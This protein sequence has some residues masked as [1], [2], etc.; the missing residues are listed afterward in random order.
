M[1]SLNGWLKTAPDHVLREQWQW[2][3]RYGTWR[4]EGWYRP[5]EH[6]LLR[7]AEQRTLPNNQPSDAEDAPQH[8]KEVTEWSKS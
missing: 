6:E 5:I 1:D 8:S 2:W 4:N 7:R 3:K